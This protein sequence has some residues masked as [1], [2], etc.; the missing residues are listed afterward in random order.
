[1][2]GLIHTSAVKSVLLYG[3][4]LYGQMPLS[5][6]YGR[7]FLRGNFSQIGV[8]QL[9]RGKFSRIVKNIWLMINLFIN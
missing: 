7:L 8:F 6:L 5:I 4:S 3:H 1:M 9:L 2:F